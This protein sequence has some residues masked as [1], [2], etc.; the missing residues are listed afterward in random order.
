M[1]DKPGNNLI[2]KRGG[3]PTK[4]SLSGS[5]LKIQNNSLLVKTCRSRCLHLIAG[6]TI[7]IGS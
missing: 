7:N 5:S 3:W 4:K 6:D 2:N 1:Q